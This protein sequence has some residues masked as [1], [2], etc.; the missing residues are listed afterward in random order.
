MVN[1][2]ERNE[3]F[4]GR[5]ILVPQQWLDDEVEG[6][7]DL[8]DVYRTKITKYLHRKAVGERRWEFIDPD[9]FETHFDLE[10]LES[11]LQPEGSS[12]GTQNDGN[13]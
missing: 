10:A 12:N 9:G 3:A 7:K 13:I 2:R 11:W 1:I 8:D 6:K 5:D 4:V